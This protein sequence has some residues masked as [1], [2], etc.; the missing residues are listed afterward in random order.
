[1]GNF[2]EKKLPLTENNV[3]NTQQESNC[4]SDHG[5][6]KYFKNVFELRCRFHDYCPH[7]ELL[8]FLIDARIKN[9]AKERLRKPMHQPK[10]FSE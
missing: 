5:V 10:V 6:C 4:V 1:M 8:Q 9:G 7:K 2:Y 3:T